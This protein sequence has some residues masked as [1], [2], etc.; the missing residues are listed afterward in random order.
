MCLKICIY[1][2]IYLYHLY[3][4]THPHQ[5][6]TQPVSTPHHTCSYSYTYICLHHLYL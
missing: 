4:R 5:A 3:L 1:I 6:E 2:C